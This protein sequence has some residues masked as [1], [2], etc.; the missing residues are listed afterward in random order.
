MPVARLSHCNFNLLID[1]NFRVNNRDDVT[2]VFPAVIGGPDANFRGIQVS[3]I[4]IGERH[5]TEF[6][7]SVR[8]TLEGNDHLAVIN[9]DRG[10]CVGFGRIKGA[11]QF[12]HCEKNRGEGVTL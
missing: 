12:R 9:R 4:Q 3:N 6:V 8:V 5:C 7:T 2:F 10:D 11:G 1:V